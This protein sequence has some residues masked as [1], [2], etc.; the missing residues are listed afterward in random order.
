MNR[1]FKKKIG[2]ITPGNMALDKN[3]IFVL[4]KCTTYLR[5]HLNRYSD[6]N[7]DSIDLACWILGGEIQ[8][9]DEFLLSCLS[10]D[11]NCKDF[12]DAAN[13]PDEYSDVITRLLMRANVSVRKKYEKLIFKLLDQ[14]VRTLRYRG[15][16]D[17]EESI[18]FLKKM[19]KL[20][21]Q[22]EE[23]CTFL[24]II[25]TYGEPESFFEDY[26]NCD[27]YRGRK[28]LLNIL[29]IS[30][31][32][33]NG[34]L[35]NLSK[36][37]IIGT[38]SR[39]FDFEWDFFCLIQNPSLEGFSGQFYSR[40]PCN[41]VPLENH[42]ID[43]NKIDHVL[44]LLSEK[45][46]TST[47][48]LFY[49][50]PGT[51]KSSF[52][53]GIAEKLGI[54]AHEIAKNEENESI[55]RR[56]AL[57]ACLN[58][59]NTGHGS[60]I[61]VDEADNLLNT[62]DS[63]FVRG[64]TQDKGWINQHLEEPG[65]RVIWVTNKIKNIEPS[66]RRRFAFSIHFKPF[67]QCQRIQLWN[68]ILCINK[69]KRLFSQSDIERYAKEYRVNAGAI[70]LAVRKA[71]ETGSQSKNHFHRSVAMALDAYVTLTHSGEKP[72]NKDRIE[73]DYTLDGLNIHGNIHHIVNQLKQFDQFLR[74]SDP[75]DIKNMNLLFHGP[76]GTGKSEFARYLAES[77]SREIICKRVSDL[78]SMWVGESEKN[79]KQAF[80]EAETE[81]AI[82]IIDEA[83]SM[84]FSRDRAHQFW[85][86]TFTNEF[87]TQMERFKG[88]LICTTN[89]FKDLDEASIRRF[90]YKVAFDYLIPNGNI[91]F[92]EKL[93][94]TIIGKPLDKGDKKALKSIKGLAPGDF[95]VVRD[96]YSFYPQK[97]LNHK[98]L[99][100]ALQE[101]AK[102]KQIHKGDKPIG[103]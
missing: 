67:N 103:F 34:I 62:K 98:I 5:R 15:E 61:L 1:R 50:P 74:Q 2:R 94:V 73:K 101:E 12:R 96:R 68:S 54:P 76:P 11:K 23:F 31:K 83:D 48:L 41:T 13:D 93:L 70:D 21:D 65:A 80:V 71:I 16:S 35:I 82:L 42:F 44:R 63:W 57:I 84:L 49:G 60:L 75:D 46:E 33:L 6:F 22:E 100:D 3:E 25:K 90:N 26:L 20:T 69:R 99:I 27:K 58:M 4:Q 86:I 72:V 47:H 88:I 9:I 40:I 55:N 38:N 17:I 8:K 77:L 95:K 18:G 66:V 30:R 51:G 43:K 102:L 97:E 29:G 10:E 87:L 91:I 92:Y 39:G 56:A 81:E 14:K 52:A 53:Y 45:R 28:Y 7:Q 36:I 85:E 64:E 59:T 79:I 37:G 19:F 32:E 89:R 78:Q 24:F